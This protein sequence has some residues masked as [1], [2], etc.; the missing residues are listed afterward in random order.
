MSEQPVPDS[1]YALDDEG[2]LWVRGTDGWRCPVHELVPRPWEEVD[3]YRGPMIPLLPDPNP[4]ADGIP[5]VCRVVRR[6]QP[7]GVFIEAPTGR[8]IRWVSDS[9]AEE[10]GLPVPPEPAPSLPERLREY[11]DQCEK[12]AG[13]P[14]APTGAPLIREAAD[15]LEAGSQP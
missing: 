1:G 11:A 14:G 7:D 12:A 9:E 13:W 4:D 10:M 2:D 5:V 3:L 8:A 6:H 15:A